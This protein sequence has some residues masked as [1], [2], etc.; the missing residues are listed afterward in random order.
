MLLLD[1]NHCFRIIARDPRLLQRLQDAAVE[2][3]VTSAIVAGELSYGASISQR[4]DENGA[5]VARFL[6]AIAVVPI[7]PSVAHEYGRLKGALLDRFG[8]RERARR[9][10]FNLASLGFGDNDLWIAA[11]ALDLGAVLVSADPDFERIGEVA[12][13]ALENWMDS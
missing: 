12:D 6:D 7:S 3:I 8:P 10:D 13:L 5:A 2:T 4:R 1:T 11:S 9:R